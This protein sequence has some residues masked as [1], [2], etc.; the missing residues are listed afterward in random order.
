MRDDFLR[1]THLPCGKFQ[2][3]C[4]VFCE[5]CLNGQVNDIFQPAFTSYS[6]A[7]QMTFTQNC[8]LK[9]SVRFSRKLAVCFFAVHVISTSCASAM[10]VSRNVQLPFL[11]SVSAWFRRKTTTSP[12]GT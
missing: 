1:T 7:V 11:Y 4:R 12:T 3:A 10:V 8:V 6:A 9:K 2:A 5:G